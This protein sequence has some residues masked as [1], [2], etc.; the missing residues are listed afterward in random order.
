MDVVPPLVANSQASLLVLPGVRPLHHPAMPP[1]PLLRFDSWPRNTR[2]DASSAQFLSVSSRRVRLVSMQLGRPMARRTM[3][4]LHIRD[5]IQQGEQF[6]D[7]MN[8]GSRQT[9]GQRQALSVDEKMMLATRLR[10]VRRVLAR[11]DPPFEARTV[12]ESIETRLKSTKPCCPSSSSRA[13]WSFSNTPARVHCSSRLQ[14]VIP[15][16]PNCFCGSSSQGIP[17]LS[18]KMMASNAALSSAR[19]RPGFFFLGTGISGASRS[20]SASGTSSRAMRHGAHDPLIRPPYRSLSNLTVVARG[21]R[22]VL[23]PRALAAPG[24]PHREGWRAGHPDLRRVPRSRAFRSRPAPC[25]PRRRPP[26]GDP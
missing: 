26:S 22:G 10:S 5:G 9:L 1:Q 23:L 21:A 24:R 3:R 14:A 6:M 7:V 16:S 17:V 18:T 13:R 15:D 20:H 4:L 2:N 12:E 11:M 8:V 25:P 19:G